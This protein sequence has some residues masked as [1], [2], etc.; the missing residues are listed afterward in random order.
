[1]TPSE[2]RRRRAV[3]L[4]SEE[5]LCANLG[6]LAP[7]LDVVMFQGHFRG[8]CRSCRLHLDAPVRVAKARVTREAKKHEGQLPLL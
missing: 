3:A 1:M 2:W 4:A 5:G 6:C 7:P 8:F